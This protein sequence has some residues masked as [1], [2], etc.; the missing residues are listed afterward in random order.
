MHEGIGAGL[1]HLEQREVGLLVGADHLGR[2]RRAVVGDEGH[3]GGVLDDVVVGDEIARRRDEEA[4][5]LRLR[6][7]RAHRVRLLSLAVL[8]AELL[9]E[10]LERVARLQ[11]RHLRALVVA[12][13]VLA[14][15]LAGV[16]RVHLHLDRDDRVADVL[17]DVGER[18][19]GHRDR[20]LGR[21]RIGDRAM[22][23]R[24]A[25][26]N[27]AGQSKRARGAEQDGPCRLT[28]TG[29]LRIGL[30]HCRLR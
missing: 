6:D 20:V 25:T 16:G 9:E 13:A 22:R 23:Q 18:G 24:H 12:V 14:A 1:G 10:T 26:G 19:R 11:L 15:A 4:G 17:D 29:T 28:L 27:R 7:V 5:A 21:R 2:K 3:L 30:D 8:L